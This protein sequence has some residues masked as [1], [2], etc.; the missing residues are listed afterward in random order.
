MNKLPAHLLRHF[1][2]PL[3]QS[4]PYLRKVS[5]RNLRIRQKVRENLQKARKEKRQSAA[6]SLRLPVE[7]TGDDA[8]NLVTTKQNL[9]RYLGIKQHQYDC[10]KILAD[11]EQV[12]FWGRRIPVVRRWSKKSSSPKLGLGLFCPG[13]LN[14]KSSA[15]FTTRN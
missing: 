6:D 4:Y 3:H 13:T 9:V 15:R 12:Q 14:P 5:F 2:L 8:G 7:R 10:F 1:E 11:L